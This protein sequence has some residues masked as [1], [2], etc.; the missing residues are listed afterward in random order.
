MVTLPCL[1]GHDLNAYILAGMQSDHESTERDEAEEKLRRGMY[2]FIREGSTERN[3]ADLIGLVTRKTVARCCFATDDCHADI[4]FEK[5]HI[6][7]CVRRAVQCG[8]EPELALRMA[9]LSAAERFGLSGIAE[10]LPRDGGQISVLLMICVSSSS[11][12]FLYRETRLDP[13]F[14]LPS[15]SPPS[16]FTCRV[17]SADE[18][19]DHG[20][21]RSPCYRACAPPDNY[22]VPAISVEAK[23]IPDV[24]S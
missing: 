23:D 17:P 16:P 12:K 11:K 2:L 22:R 15:A 8:L 21:R 6:D 13:A 5:G 19:A 1:R 7:R 3:I 4:L 14:S 18:L 20:Q 10:H 9:T 24:P